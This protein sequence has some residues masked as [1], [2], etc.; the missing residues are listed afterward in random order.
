VRISA[1][2]DAA[3]RRGVTAIAGYHVAGCQRMPVAGVSIRPAGRRKQTE[4]SR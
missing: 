3:H 4:Q 1:S 2:R